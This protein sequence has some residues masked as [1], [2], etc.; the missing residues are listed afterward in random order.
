MQQQILLEELS[1]NPELLN[2]R[3]DLQDFKAEVQEL[4]QTKLQE[5][6]D[7]AR[8]GKYQE[9]QE[10]NNEVAS[11][12]DIIATDKAVNHIYLTSQRDSFPM[13]NLS[14]NTKEQIRELASLCPLT[15]GLSVYS[16][17]EMAHLIDSEWINYRH[18]CEEGTPWIG[19]RLAQEQKPLVYP[20]PNTGDFYVEA[21]A[22]SQVQIRDLMGRLV[23][24]QDILENTKNYLQ[25]TKQKM[26]IYVLEIFDQKG[27]SI[28]TQKLVLKN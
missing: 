7:L 23:L 11:Q 14:A 20:N 22:G 4:P 19:A 3:Q 28:A 24:Q 6:K 10:K 21:S 13:R 12:N 27:Q 18:Q 25:L 9:A 17:R 1:L 15:H 5:V 8:E 2:G 16:A 26:G